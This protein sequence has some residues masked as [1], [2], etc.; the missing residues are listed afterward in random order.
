MYSRAGADLVI[1]SPEHGTYAVKGFF[2][3]DP[4]PSLVAGDDGTTIHGD[5]AAQFAG[6][7]APAQYA[8]QVAGALGAPI[9]QVRSLGTAGTVT[10]THAD[11]TTAVLKVGDPLYL[12][13]SIE[14]STGANVGIMLIDGTSLALDQ[15]GEL[16]LDELVYN[17][18]DKSGK[19][20][21]SLV[22]GA[23]QF[24]SGTCTASA[25]MGPNW[26]GELRRVLVS[27]Q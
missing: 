23:A 12:D 20:T 22:S 17:P 7:I 8:G 15:S 2:L 21:I 9:G 16:V 27:S 18:S 24:I 14:T 1:T 4:P 5:V 11:G 19:A 13:D 25:P 3:T 6:P 10:V 26:G